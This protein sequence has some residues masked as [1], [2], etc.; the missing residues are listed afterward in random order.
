MLPPP[1]PSQANN[2][3]TEQ[4]KKEGGLHYSDSGSFKE[5][6]NLF[7]DHLFLLTELNYFGR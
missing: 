5:A 3:S 4:M 7:G 2:S 1:H 6:D